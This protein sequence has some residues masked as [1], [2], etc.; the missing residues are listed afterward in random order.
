MKDVNK[1]ETEETSK[2]L[3]HDHWAYIQKTLEKQN[4]NMCEIFQKPDQKLLDVAMEII[5]YHYKTAFIHGYKH[6]KKDGKCLV[7]HFY[8]L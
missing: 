7:K 2:K 8:T 4:K 3:A 1:K 6:G 5:E